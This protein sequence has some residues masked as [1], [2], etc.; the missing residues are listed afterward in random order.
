MKLQAFLLL[1]I[2]GLVWAQGGGRGNQNKEAPVTPVPFN[3]ILQAKQEPQNW[4]TYGG[5]YNSNR[6]SEL[7]QITAALMMGVGMFLFIRLT[8]IPFDLVCAPGAGASCV[9]PAKL[10]LFLQTILATAV[11]GFIYVAAAY[12]LRINELQEVL[13]YLQGRFRRAKV[14]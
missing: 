4:M 1:S 10:V 9:E 6:Y 11:G 8:N 3:R 5:G 13:A 14:S 2:T 12:I 7:K